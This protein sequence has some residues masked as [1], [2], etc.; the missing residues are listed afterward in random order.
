MYPI[1]EGM[2]ATV[3]ILSSTTAGTAGTTS[4]TSSTSTTSTSTRAIP[5]NFTM[6][7]MKERMPATVEILSSTAATT[8]STPKTTEFT[9]LGSTSSTEI[10][11]DYV[12]ANSPFTCNGRKNGHYA[13]FFFDCK[14]FHQCFFHHETYVKVYAQH[15]VFAC[16]RGTLFNQ[17]IKNCDYA[18]KVQCSE[19]LIENIIKE[20]YSDPTPVPTLRTTESVTESV[21]GPIPEYVTESV[22]ESVTGPIPESVAESVTGP[23]PEYVAE[24]VTGPIPEYVAESVTGPI[25]EYVAESVT[26]PIPEYV[27]ESVSGPIPESSFRCFPDE[28]KHGQYFADLDSNCSIYH[29]CMYTTENGTLYDAHLSFRCPMGTLFDQQ[30]E[31][32]IVKEEV[33]YQIEKAGQSVCHVTFDQP[34]YMKASEIIAASPELKTCLVTRLGGFH[35]IMSYM[36]A[37][38]YNMDGSGLDVLWQT[39]Y[40]GATVQHMLNGHAYARALHAHFLTSAA[41]TTL[42]LSQPHC[43]DHVDTNQ[44]RQ[45]LSSL[46]DKDCDIHDIQVYLLIKNLVDV[47]E[48]ASV[49]G[50]AFRTGKLWINYIR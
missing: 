1:K 35:L 7:P 28:H 21:T 17:S 24:S 30:I 32:C 16:G 8:I 41:L 48:R 6:Y 40:A 42:L 23:I 14:F 10:G 50:A 33:N 19:E 9:T 38:G 18:H 36:G 11:V 13:D 47:I 29:Q 4:S 39:V 26:G 20:Q 12:L 22:T 25:P 34:L 3:E 43:L 5:A 15:M 31:S 44:L 37:I 45:K 27:A 46:I 2:P 49:D